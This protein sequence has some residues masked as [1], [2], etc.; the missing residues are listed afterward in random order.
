MQ[1]EAH[2]IGQ[3]IEQQRDSISVW[4]FLLRFRMY[5]SCKLPNKNDD[6]K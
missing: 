6:D 2:V 5:I 1:S 4:V 3:W